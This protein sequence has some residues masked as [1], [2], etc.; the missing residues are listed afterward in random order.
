MLDFRH[1]TFRTLCGL[2]SYAKT[3]QQLHIT[4]PAV[5]QHIKYLESYYQVMLVAEKGRSFALTPAGEELLL[6]I[7]ACSNG[8]VALQQRMQQAGT[9]PQ[10][11][12]VGAT[13]SV[14]EELMPDIL[15]KA[16]AA[17][18]QTAF[19]L[20]VENTNRLLQKLQNGDVHFA[21]IE[22]Y[23]DTRLFSYLPFSTEEFIG[24][25]SASSALAGQPASYGS[26]LAYR[27]ILRERGSGSRE[28]C[29]EI[30]HENHITLGRFAGIIEV[31]NLAAIKKLVAADA[32]ISFLYKFSVQKELS[33][34]E[35]AQLH[36]PG[37]PFFRK[38]HFIY[39]KNSLTGIDY[40]FWFTQLGNF[41][42]QSKRVPF[43]NTKP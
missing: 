26:L 39:P 41:Y 13:R 42:A 33:R 19:Q 25:C 21:L 38:L 16:L 34:G 14:G 5:S 2:G 6:F 10:K 15:A 35:L 3:A 27:Q 23:F 11:I 17:H 43:A 31:N 36:L 9:V 37:G 30:L 22:G 18:P 32:G 29:E 28:I 8:L 7:Q 20:V 1:E 4:Q 40:T 24:V 12:V